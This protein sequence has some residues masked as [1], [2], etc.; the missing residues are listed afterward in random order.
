MNQLNNKKWK[1]DEEQRKKETEALSDGTWNFCYFGER[2]GGSWKRERRGRRE[3][4]GARV[5]SISRDVSGILAVIP[6]FR[7]NS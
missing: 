3:V 5:A 1:K 4:G 6:R 7:D 2:K